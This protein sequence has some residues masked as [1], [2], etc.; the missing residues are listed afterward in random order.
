[1]DYT[2]DNRERGGMILINDAG[3]I[4]L[5]RGVGT[6]KWSFPKGAI[7]PQDG[8]D[9]LKTAVREVA[10]EA[11][12]IAEEHYTVMLK[13][14]VLQVHNNYFW[15]GQMRP[16]APMPRIPRDEISEYRW[17]NPSNCRIDTSALNVGVRRWL[18]A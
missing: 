2:D 9:L 3:E 7:E 13:R 15:L 6:G 12:L 8:T 11:G 1:M 4:L 18:K 10:E 5:L 16:G 17:V 14:P